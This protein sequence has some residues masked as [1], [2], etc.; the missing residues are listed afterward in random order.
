M[1]ETIVETQQKNDHT[2]NEDDTTLESSNV[3]IPVFT[4]SNKI[5]Q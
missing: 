5:K 3:R 2:E 1:S 4:E